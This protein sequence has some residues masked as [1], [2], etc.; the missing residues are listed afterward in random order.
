[1]NTYTTIDEFIIQYPPGVQELLQ[2][3]RSVIRETVPEA[4]EAIVYGIPTFRFHGNLVHF[5]AYKNHIGFYPT[6]SGVSHFKDRLAGYELSKGTIQFPIDQPL[7]YDLIRE[8]VA[9]RVKENLEKAA[10]KKKK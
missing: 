2:K 3:L 9:F 7:P 1:M 5:S 8:I 10:S 4:T 6:S